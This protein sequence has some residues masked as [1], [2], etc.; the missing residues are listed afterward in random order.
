M[1]HKFGSIAIYCDILKIYKWKNYTLQTFIV[2][3]C[4]NINI[5][6]KITTK[7][8]CRFFKMYLYVFP[9]IRLCFF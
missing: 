2:I 6:C 8:I 4:K 3:T 1:K 9:V 5:W 7:Q